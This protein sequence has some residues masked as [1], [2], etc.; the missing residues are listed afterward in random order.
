MKTPISYYGGKQNLVTTILP[1]IPKHNLYC[2]PFLGGGAIFFAKDRSP[3]EVINDTNKELI[4]FYRIVQTDFVSLEKKIMITLHSR[5]QHRKASVIYNNP[6]MD[7]FS[8]LDRAWAFWTLASQSFGSIIDGSWG[9][10]RTRNTTSK[11]VKNKRE[12]FTLDY[13]IRLQDIQIEC[14]DALRI[15]RSRDAEDA[16]FYCDPPYY[17]AD[18]GHYDGYTLDD[19]ENLLKTLAGIKGKFLLSSYPSPILKEYAQANGWHQVEKEQTVSVNN[20]SGKRGKSKIEVFTAN[21]PL[22]A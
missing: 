19:F 6:D 4:N 9:Y 15:I 1:M 3:V 5:D 17:N 2:E 14:T 11:K 21:Y 13:S 8:E 12:T 16:F 22:K 18:M 7:Q 10:D 20:K